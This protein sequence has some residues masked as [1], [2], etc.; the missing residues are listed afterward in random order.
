MVLL[1]PNVGGGTLSVPMNSEDGIPVPDRPERNRGCGY[2]HAQNAHR[3]Q[4][5]RK[6]GQNFI[7]DVQT[8]TYNS[9]DCGSETGC[10]KTSHLTL[11]HIEIIGRGRHEYY[12][13]Y[14]YQRTRSPS[15]D[16]VP[17]AA[18]SEIAK[19]AKTSL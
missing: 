13:D 16:R 6:K 14:V 15:P 1:P 3:R 9:M 4:L 19:P 2:G 10:H 5:G 12:S 18:P 17:S 11:V 7:F 8:R